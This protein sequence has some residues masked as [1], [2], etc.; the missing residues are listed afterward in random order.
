ML[1]AVLS[2]L[3]WFR[4]VVL[5]FFA[6]LPFSSRY[7]NPEADLF[8][9]ITYNVCARIGY[10][11]F[12]MKSKR[13][14]DEKAVLYTGRPDV[15]YIINESRLHERLQFFS[16][17][18]VN[19]GAHP[20]LRES[21]EVISMGAHPSGQ[22]RVFP[23]YRYHSWELLCFHISLSIHK[24]FSLLFVPSIIIIYACFWIW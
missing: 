9:P 3:L 4:S 14:M 7:F 10:E 21:Q 16:V 17:I 19:F 24:S 1:H 11:L 2:P 6:S 5:I 13:T 12:I 22:R 15:I 18:Y 23:F 20:P 8:L